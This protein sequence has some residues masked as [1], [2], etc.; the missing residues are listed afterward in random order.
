MNGQFQMTRRGWLAGAGAWLAGCGGSGGDDSAEPEGWRTV[1]SFTASGQA[2][3]DT[4]DGSVLVVG[5]SRGERV[6]SGGVERFDPVLRRFVR[7]GELAAGRSGH[8][9]L[10]LAGGRLLVV[11]GLTSQNVW[12]FAE[13]I[14]ERSGATGHAGAL[15]QPRN[16][17]TAVALPD[18]RAL[19]VG[20]LGRDTAELYDPATQR[21][22]LVASRMAHDRLFASA[23]LLA[24]GRVLVAGGDTAG[25][26]Y[27][28]AELFDPRTETFRALDAPAGWRRQLHAAARLAD[29]RVLLAGGEGPENGGLPLASVLCFD[30][31]TETFER[32]AP[33]AEPR[34][35]AS[36]VARADGRL[37]LF[38]GSTVAAAVSAT[39]EAWSPA[40]GRALPPLPGPRLWHGVH[41]L[42]DGRWLVFGGDDGRA[43]YTSDVLMDRPQWSV[44]P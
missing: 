21:W 5:G 31:A 15:V 2:S 16:W 44:E 4:A 33:L 20:G 7:I 32:L 12:P 34:S 38:G 11:G 26:A 23:T 40:G 3:T 42:G 25:T 30:P 27:T 35:A 24:D 1:S 28:F 19:A 10:R 39:V 14:D 8:R 43:G 29:G 36:V 17:H 6:L 37:W 22:R 18:G 9:L 41:R 13:W